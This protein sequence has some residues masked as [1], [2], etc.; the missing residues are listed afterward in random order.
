ML[1]FMR[2]NFCHADSSWSVGFCRGTWGSAGFVDHTVLK[3]SVSIFEAGQL[4][5]EALE[6]NHFPVKKMRT[7]L[8]WSLLLRAQH[9]LGSA[10][11]AWQEIPP[12]WNLFVLF[13]F[14]FMKKT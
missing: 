10:D 4:S 1:L 11:S 13:L 6:V 3:G 2:T 9:F 8:L 14:H 7:G 5:K 12:P